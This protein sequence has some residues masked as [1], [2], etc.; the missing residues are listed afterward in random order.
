MEQILFEPIVLTFAVI[1]V[2]CCLGKVKIFNVSVGITGV[3]I[4]A[5]AVGYIISLFKG[6]SDYKLL[7]EMQ[8]NI[9]MFSTFGTA[10]FVSIIGITVGYLIKL[11]CIN[12]VKVFLIGVIMVISSF[13][14]MK[15]L[16]TIDTQIIFEEMIG[17]F[18]GA[19]TTTPG[20]AA[21]C[22]NDAIKTSEIVFGYS[23][24]YLFG[25]V[26]TVLFV[27]SIVKDNM[28]E[29]PIRV[30]TENKAMSSE[31]FYVVV[32]IGLAIVFGKF[33]GSVSVH[34]IT[35]G[36]SVGMLCAGILIGICV[37]KFI[38]CVI[39]SKKATELIRNLGLSLFFVGTGIPAGIQLSRGINCKM[40]LYGMLMTIIPIMIGWFCCRVILKK[41]KNSSL[42]V[43]AGG[44][45]STPAIS[46][47][48][49]KDKKVKMEEYS[50][51]Y[52]MAL[53]TVLL[54]IKISCLRLI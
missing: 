51:S 5:V 22:E 21:A 45:T 15:I 43:I 26:F 2:G 28:K 14:I 9:K 11:K 31:F 30:G 41:D 36:D 32:Q 18:C 25:V 40:I 46:V 12:Q 53:I 19:L 27:Q 17:V 6:T 3:L 54:L 24:A 47:L 35:L 52:A 49:Q 29:S 23:S 16:L 34:G 38:P 10:L 50:I 7:V 1:V 20:L 42:A 44:M 39:V 8:T 33:F 13:A 37:R 48:M 4:S